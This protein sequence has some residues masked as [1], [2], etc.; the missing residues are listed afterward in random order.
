MSRYTNNENIVSVQLNKEQKRRYYNSL[1]DPK[2]PNQ[3]TD[4]YVITVV[5]D[6]LD[7]L[8]WQYYSDPTQWWI[9]AAANPHVRKDSMFLDPGMQVRIPEL[10]QEVTIAL[11]TLNTT[12]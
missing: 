8:A 12:R 7:A 4:I 6:R 2:I 5:G 10:S 11:E 9:I 3:D 1:I